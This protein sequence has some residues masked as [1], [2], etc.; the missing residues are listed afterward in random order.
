MQRFPSCE[1][2][3]FSFRELCSRAVVAR[4]LSLVLLPKGASV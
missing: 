3:V 2:T 1:G 4:L